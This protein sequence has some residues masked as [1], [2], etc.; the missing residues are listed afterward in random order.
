MGS[1]QAQLSFHL[2]SLKTGDFRGHQKCGDSAE[3]TA[4]IGLGEQ[5][6]QVRLCSAGYPGF[7]AVEH[8]FLAFALGKQILVGGLRASGK[9]GQGETAKHAPIAQSR[10][11]DLFLL[12]ATPLPDGQCA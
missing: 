11:V 7:L 5:Q 9:F 4:G 1:S 8:P 10:Q 2:C 12:F 6:A 3:T